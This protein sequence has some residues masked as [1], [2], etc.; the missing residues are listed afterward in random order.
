MSMRWYAKGRSRRVPVTS[1]PEEQIMSLSRMLLPCVAVFALSLPATGQS[2]YWIDTSLEGAWHVS[3]NWSHGLPTLDKFVYI[4]NGGKAHVSTDGQAAGALYLGESAGQSGSLRVSA[5]SLDVTS[6]FVGRQGSGSVLQ[7]GGDVW[8]RDLAVAQYLAGHGEYELTSGTLEVL[9]VEYI[10]LQGSAT[11]TQTGGSNTTGKIDLA[12]D[13]SAL[14]VSYE[15]QDGLMDVGRLNVGRSGRAAFTQSGGTLTVDVLA[16]G[17]GSTASGSTFELEAGT[18]NA[19]SAYIGDRG[20][21]TFTQRGGTFTLSD[22]LTL[23]NR[24]AASYPSSRG[25]YLL[26]GGDLT[27]QGD[28]LM[29]NGS[30]DNL[31]MQQ[32]GTL[33]VD[34]TFYVGYYGPSGSNASGTYMMANG[35]LEV[36]SLHVGRSGCLGHLQLLGPAATVKVGAS[37]ILDDDAVFDALPGTTIHMTGAQFDVGPNVDLA[38]LSPGLRWLQL[39]FEGGPADTDPFEVAGEDLGP[40]LSGFHANGGNGALQGLTLGGVDIGRVRLVN[41]RQHHA[42]TEAIYV[43]TLIVGPGSELDLNGLNLYCVNCLVDP[44]ASLINGTL[45]DL[46]AGDYNGDGVVTLDDF[47]AFPDCLSGPAGGIGTG[48]GS[49][50]FNTDHDVDLTDFA[51]FQEACQG[52]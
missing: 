46:H 44:A 34:G 31:I 18:V 28:L 17:N 47:G 6:G 45:T 50:D 48:C 39:V 30:R 27:V 37:L 22:D 7:T 24:S 51:A 43:N 26:E 16:V 12:Y 25:T 20:S 5:G 40:T 14:D 8:F 42:G 38:S 23:G 33:E 2:T 41:N 15:L 19:E 10:G 35:T 9:S 36:G 11:F 29:A 13:S 3:D 52:T 1:L 49:F 4:T 32:N 21:A